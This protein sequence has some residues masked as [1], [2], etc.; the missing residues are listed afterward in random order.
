VQ[1]S[2]RRAFSLLE[3]I[4]SIV[5][6]GIAL[7]AMPMVL[8]TTTEMVPEILKVEAVNQAYILNRNIATYFWDENDPD[9]HNISHLLDTN[10]VDDDE[11]DRYP[12]ATS[13]YRRGRFANGRRFFDNPTYPTRKAD[14]GPESDEDDIAKYDDIDDFHN[15]S[16]T[17]SKQQGDYLLDMKVVSK[18]FYIDDEADYT[19]RKIA[20]S[21]NPSASSKDFTNVKMIE[22]SVYDQDDQLVLRMYS[23]VQN[24]GSFN[25]AKREF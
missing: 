16:Y 2:H 20:L 7:L 17:V 11:F 19:Q 9:D 13:I 8:R 10:G 12:D 25:I 22:V 4:V 23:W 24:I 1:V 14:L 3:L 6:L 15:F 18:I 21:F 5:V